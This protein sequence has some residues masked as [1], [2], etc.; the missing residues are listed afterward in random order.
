MRLDRR[1]SRLELAVGAADR[2][3]CPACGVVHGAHDRFV[4][5]PMELDDSPPRDGPDACPACGR[6]LVVRM[7]AI[8]LDDPATPHG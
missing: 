3:T 5:A 7:G 1:L 6:R 2:R 8:T 4:L